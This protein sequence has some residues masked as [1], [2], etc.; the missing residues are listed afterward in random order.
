MTFSDAQSFVNFVIL[1]PTQLPMGTVQSEVT[2]RK[3]TPTLRS[4]IRFEITGEN[5]AFRIK[6]FFYD[7]S[8]PGIYADTNLVAQGKPFVLH[9]IAGFLGTDYKGNVAAAHARW[10]TQVELS[11]LRGHFEEEELLA[12]MEG[13][14]P[15]VKEA[16]AEVGQK[17]Y[18]LTSH[19]AR[20][21][22]PRWAEGDPVN[23]VHW[24]TAANYERGY[25]TVEGVSIPM[26]FHSYLCDSIGHF[27]HDDGMEHQFLFR[28]GRN[29]TDCIWIWRAPKS[30]RSP[31]PESTGKNIGKR[32]KWNIEKIRLSE[33]EVIICE[34]ATSVPGWQL[35]WEQQR[36]DVHIHFRATDKL[37]REQVV[38]LADQM[39]ASNS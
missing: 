21:H 13:L 18:A 34:Q 19:T 1:E 9:D 38:Q 39:L 26:R 22:V 2:V 12:F 23:R 20:Y 35:H 14:V 6:Q 8:I 11:V 31:F 3:E 28:D 36:Y 24:Q 30:L 16:V 7:W 4:S 25:D 29:H 17:P 33:K 5:R 15:A 10:F 27:Q 37:T 32:T